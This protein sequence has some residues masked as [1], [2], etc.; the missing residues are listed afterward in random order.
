MYDAR[1]GCQRY[2]F[3]FD[4][5]NS[6]NIFNIMDKCHLAVNHD[7]TGRE[8]SLQS[9]Q[10]GYKDIRTLNMIS[11]LIQVGDLT[12]SNHVQ[13]RPSFLFSHNTHLSRI[14]LL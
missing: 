14:C 13:V 12:F 7:D 2:D 8:L 5:S 11:S 6:V 3:M 10:I 9:C 4:L 1:R